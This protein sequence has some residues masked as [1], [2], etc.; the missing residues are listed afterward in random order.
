MCPIG[1]RLR[2]APGC[3]R[4]DVAILAASDRDDEDDDPLFHDLIDEAV[5]VLEHDRRTRSR[6]QSSGW[7]AFKSASV[8]R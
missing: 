8:M 7:R 2:D 4:V 6:I 1:W 3:R 5:A